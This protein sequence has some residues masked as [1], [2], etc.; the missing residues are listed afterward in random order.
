MSKTA[1]T[2]A[3][4]PTHGGVAVVTGADGGIG[5]EFCRALARRGYSLVMVSDRTDSLRESAARIGAEYRCQTWPLTLDLTAPDAPERL[6]DF[7]VNRD[8]ADRTEVLVNN[9]GVFSFD[10]LTLTSP[11]RIN[12]FVDL[13]VRAVAQMCRLFGEWFAT[14][15]RGYILNMSSMSCWMPMPGLALYA[16][17]KAFMRVFSRS[18]A[19]ELQDSGVKVMVATPGGIATT[20]FGLPPR[21]MKLA[22]RLHAVAPP[23]RFAEQAVRRLFKGRHQYINGLLNRISIVAVGSTPRWMRMQVKRRLLDKDIRRP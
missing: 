8:L 5:M 13:H 4:T 16:S 21:L 18:L 6:W 11:R 7:L 17:T 14:R 2:H 20:L 19:L 10:Y 23:D 12:L 3:T 15:R 1:D 9:A 22:L